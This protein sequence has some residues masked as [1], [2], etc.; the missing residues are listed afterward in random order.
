M[1]FYFEVI[2]SLKNRIKMSMIYL[3]FEKNPVTVFN[4][5]ENLYDSAYVMFI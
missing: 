5:I 1:K 4:G 2:S 3:I